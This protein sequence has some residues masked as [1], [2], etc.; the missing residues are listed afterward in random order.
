MKKLLATVIAL[1]VCSGC[2]VGCDSEIEPQKAK[3]KADA[4]DVVI[5]VWSSEAGAQAVW[6]ELVDK[7]NSTTGE[8][9]NIFINWSTTTDL[10]K[11]DVAQQ[12]GQL[13]HIFNVNSNQLKKFMLNGDLMPINDLPGGE[14]FLADYGQA[15]LEGSNCK[16]GK[17]YSVY[18][19]VRTAGLI[20]NKDLF[21][22]AGIVD[23][24]GEVKAPETISELRRAAKKITDVKN[25]IYGYA[26]PLKFGL[27]YTTNY[28]LYTSFNSTGKENVI[29]YTD[30]DKLEVKCPGYK[31][32]YQWLLDLKDDGT[33][34]PGAETLDNDTARAYF[35]Q[36]KIGMFPAI[37]WDVGVYTDQFP[38]KCDWDVVEFPVLDG[39]E[40]TGNYWNQRGGGM[41]IGKTAAE[42]NPEETMEVY[43]FIYS[44]ETR[45]EMFERG[46][47]LSCKTDV[48]ENVDESKVNPKFLKFAKLV[49]EKQRYAV[50]ETYVSE[51]E[52]W[53]VLFQKVWQNQLTLD[54][55]VKQYEKDQT[56]GLRKGVEKGT[57][58]IERQK[59]V[60]KYLEGDDSADVTKKN[61]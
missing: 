50:E 26:F 41:I 44:L 10:Q 21:K 30:L 53:V 7:W 27:T 40:H 35:A 39:H 16:D 52:T 57:Y 6:E 38:A 3:G 18:M 51:G 19:N 33:L 28:P 20:I 23:E 47:N 13:P 2:F 45:T 8:E 61:W 37:S 56:D 58:S 31:D 55:A 9:K 22:K 48:L 24:N 15:G 32:M 36:G 11:M 60:I 29:T 1:F 25:G 43:K 54:Q 34:F 17:Q 42:K 46:I 49:N 12:N 14:E 5:D 4:D 59:N